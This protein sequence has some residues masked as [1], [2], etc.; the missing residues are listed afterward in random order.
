MHLAPDPLRAKQTVPSHPG[1]NPG[2]EGRAG[3]TGRGISSEAGGVR[4]VAACL[5]EPQGH[6]APGAWLCHV[7]GK[8]LTLT[9]QV[10]LI[11]IAL[12]SWCFV[13][14][15]LSH[16]G[17]EGHACQPHTSPVGK[18]LPWPNSPIPQPPALTAP[19]PQEPS[20]G[21]EGWSQRVLVTSRACPLPL[22]PTQA[23]LSN[24]KGGRLVG[25]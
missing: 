17:G 7:L 19:R 16:A 2:R 5:G 13:F 4:R 12:G 3:C 14:L 10:W 22:P 18:G 24:S 8:A 11:E 21:L 20:P 25:R 9:P 6:G 15:P 23:A 1:C